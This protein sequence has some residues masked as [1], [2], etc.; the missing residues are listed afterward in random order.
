LRNRHC[1]AHCKEDTIAFANKEFFKL[2]GYSQEDID[3][4][5]SCTEFVFR[6]DLEKMIAQHKIRR[7]KPEDALPQ[8]EFRLVIKSGEIRTILLTIDMIPGTKRSIASLNDITRRIQMENALKESEESFRMLFEE[9]PVPIL[10]SEI[11]SG[12]ITSANKRFLKDIGMSLD[13]VTGKRGSD[14]GLLYDPEDQDRLTAAVMANGSVDDRE[15]KF[16]NRDG[17]TG[18]NLVSMRI[19]TLNKKHYCLT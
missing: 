14:L 12:S 19:V 10:L 9:S 8:Y 17:T 5:R 15:V 4:R 11:P 6:E 16:V 1:N 2:T 13:Q 18:I 7:Q 3:L